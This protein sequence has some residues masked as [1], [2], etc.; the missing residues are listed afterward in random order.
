MDEIN[1]ILQRAWEWMNYGIAGSSFTLGKLILVLFFLV[2][3]IWVT[4]WISRTV[5]DRVLGRRGIDVGVAQAVSTMLR[6][7]IVA[8]GTLVILQGA[9]IDLS[10]LTVLAGALGVGLGFGL[11]NVTSNFISGLI[12]LFERPIKVGDRVEVGQVTGNVRRIGAR[13]TTVVTN[14]NISIIVP[15]SDFITERVTNWSHG[16]PLVRLRVPVGVSYASDPEAI[17]RL[18]LEVAGR[19]DGVLAEPKP[20]VIF[21]EFGDSSLN[22]ELRVWTR[23]FTQAPAVLRSQLNFA[24]WEAFKRGGIEI[25]FPQRDLHIRSG[26]L[27]VRQ[28]PSPSQGKLES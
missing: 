10:A 27:P 28:E 4:G 25:P 17:R 18:L 12:I 1:R 19:H 6:Y 8:L 21:A 24:I 7:A 16:G 5:M 23:D 14:E 20:D 22:F 13:A 2:A 3:L 11:Q 15:N 26:T 9:G